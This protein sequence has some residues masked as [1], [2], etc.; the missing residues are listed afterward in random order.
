VSRYAPAEK[1][2]SARGKTFAVVAAQWNP[3]IVDALLAGALAAIRE[4]DGTVSG[5]HRCAGVFE[6]SPLCA[7]VARNGADGIVAL[8]CL[9]RGGTDHYAL[10][11]AETTRALSS[12]AMELAVAANPVAVAFGVLTCDTESQAEERKDKGREAALACIE[13]VLAFAAAKV[14][15]GSATRA[16]L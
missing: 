11:A 8:G 4:A 13:Q 14:S 10:L 15:P 5:V 2:L 1:S 7:R 16:G 9:I 12:L 6:V 3:H